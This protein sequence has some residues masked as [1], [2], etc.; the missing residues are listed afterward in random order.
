MDGRSIESILDTIKP[1]PWDHS[2][3]PPFEPVLSQ[4]RFR[5]FEDVTAYSLSYI[6][7]S[8]RIYTKKFNKPNSTI[9]KFIENPASLPYEALKVMKVWCMM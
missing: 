5:A 7:D 9:K 8:G 3:N 1:K 4:H 6:S 2:K